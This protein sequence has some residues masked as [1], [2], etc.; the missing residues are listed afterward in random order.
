MS[1][2]FALDQHAKT[3]EEINE[4][5]ERITHLEGFIANCGGKTKTRKIYN[6][7]SKARDMV[8]DARWDLEN[9]LLQDYPDAPLYTSYRDYQGK[10]KPLRQGATQ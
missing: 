5:I 3:A 7:L 9:E 4:I 6:K 8:V 2:E 1:K 10:L